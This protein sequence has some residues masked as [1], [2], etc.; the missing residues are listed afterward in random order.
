[1]EMMSNKHAIVVWSV[2]VTV[3]AD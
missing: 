2:Q 3:K 1:M